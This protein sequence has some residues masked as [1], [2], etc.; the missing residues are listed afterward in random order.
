MRIGFISDLHIDFNRHHKFPEV[1]AKLIVEEEL[2]TVVFL[3]DTATGA[4]GAIGFYDKLSALTKAQIR[5]VPGNHDIYAEK[6]VHLTAD[7]IEREAESNLKKILYHPKYSLLVNPVVTKRWAVTGLGGWFDYSFEKNF[8]EIDFEKAS[9][10]FVSKYLWPDEK[11]IHGGKSDYRRDRK[12]VIHDIRL[13]KEAFD[14][15]ECKGKR[16]CVAMH[17]L[18]TKSLITKYPV[19]FYSKFTNQLGSERYRSFFENNN[20]ELSISG[21]SHM[22]KKIVKNGI[23]YVNVSLGYNFQWSNP[24]DALEEIRKVMYVLE[25]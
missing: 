18:P 3:G 22:P 17:M 24:S 10:N 21:H 4:E 11:L 12:Q 5:A 8:P 9:Q 13:I 19:P 2:D 20:V 16:R 7:L 14:Q 6:A 1:M 23:V 15:E 25:D